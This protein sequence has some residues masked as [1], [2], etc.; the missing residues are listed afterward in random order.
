M[1]QVVMPLCVRLDQIIKAEEIR[2]YAWDEELALC[3]PVLEETAAQ[4]WNPRFEQAIS[5]LVNQVLAA[6]ESSVVDS[7]SDHPILGPV[8][9][10]Y[11]QNIIFLPYVLASEPLGVLVLVNADQRRL[12]AERDTLDLVVTPT[13]LA[14]RGRWQVQQITLQNRDLQQNKLHLLALLEEVERRQLV[15]ERLTREVERTKG[16]LEGILENAADGLLS[17]DR[18]GAILSANEPAAL[19]LGHS[20]AHLIHWRLV[21]LV[22]QA[23][24]EQIEGLV[25]HALAGETVKEAEILWPGV[26]GI[27]A[28]RMT[29]SPLRDDQGEIL[30]GVCI[31]SDATE[32]RRAEEQIQR[33]LK[34]VTVLREI[35]LATTST[36]DLHAILDILLKK[37]DQFLPYPAVLTVR[38]I[39]KQT[40]ELEPLAC[41]NLD[42]EA[43]KARREKGQHRLSRMVV[44]TK[45]PL[46]VANLLTD[47]RRWDPEFCRE[48]GLIS[49]LGVPLIA[50]GEVLGVLSFFSRE[51]HEFT[52]EEVGFL[53]TLASQA[54]IAIYNSQLFE[55]TKRKAREISALHTVATAISSSLELERVLEK[56]LHA[57]L[58]VTGMDAGFI[59]F[60]EGDPPRLSLKVYKGISREHISELRR[61]TRAG[62]KSE[63]VFTTERPLVFD[64]IPAGHP[65]TFRPNILA[66]GFTAAAW[67]PITLQGQVI[68]IINLM[69]RKVQT[70]PR[71]QIPLL[72]SIGAS[73]G[74]A[75][76]NARL[77]KEAKVAKEEQEKANCVKSQFISTMSHELRTPLSVIKGNVAV[78]TE[79]LFGELNPDQESRLTII[80]RNVGDLL[81]L[82]QG[83]LDIS[84]LEEGRMPVYL[85]KFYLD[86]LLSEIHVEF[87]DLMQKKGVMFEVESASFESPMLSDRMKI[88]EVLNNLLSNAVKFTRKGKVEVEARPLA[89]GDQI[90]FVVR[91]TGIGIKSENLPHIFDLFYQV[92]GSDQREFGGTGMGLNIVKRLVKHLQGEI[93]VESEFG[94]GTTFRIILPREI[95]LSNQG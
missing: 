83:I 14:L 51:E 43:W 64:S 62:G 24:R 31:M 85:E 70:F 94:A 22:P 8:G 58:S 33:H 16:H 73:L 34:R 4:T 23:A 19:L 56:A 11:L 27:Q 12:D 29:M 38:L 20:K 55:E 37:I 21:D 1:E 25:Q 32:R 26:G 84:R 7:V 6:G 35:N 53:T 50:K 75:L 80:E 48:Q 42:E 41:L 57:V 72:E 71:D 93:R 30:G 49:Y 45:A 77:F 44:S 66:Q 82:I 92:D 90:E 2:F 79:R 81:R 10:P 3:L 46:M 95:S 91:D 78:L 5:S 88:K 52:N 63:Q 17:V 69:T 74:V 68:G 76:E 65:G 47:P 60:L 86:G 54:A 89:K 59:R 61:G 36:L 15:I 18:A 28:V 40:G 13:L 67:V 39:S 9:P 87:I